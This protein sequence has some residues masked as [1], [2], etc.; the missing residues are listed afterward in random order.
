MKIKKKKN[1][2]EE[3]I[4]TSSKKDENKNEEKNKKIEIT[5]DLEDDFVLLANFGELPFELKAEKEI[6]EDE[7]M[8]E[9]LNKNIYNISQ[10]SKPSY[11][12][13]TLEEVEYVRKKFLENDDI[14]KKF[15]KKGNFIGKK[16]F[17]EALN[18]ILNSK[19]GKNDIKK[20]TIMGLKKSVLDED[21]YEEYELTIKIQKLKKKMKKVMQ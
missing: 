18:G 4:N 20:E 1:K 11:K 14:K 8:E 16:E 9:I 6:K 21:E 15:E 7:K 10:E 13:I 17:N 19:K 2:K 3:E 5:G 12:Y